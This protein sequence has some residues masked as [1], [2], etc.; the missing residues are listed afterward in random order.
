MVFRVGC[1]C[2]FLY[3]NRLLLLCDS[4]GCALDGSGDDALDKAQDHCLAV[5]VTGEGGSRRVRAEPFVQG[6]LPMLLSG[7]EW[8]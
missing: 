5:A 7:S 8:T 4:D 1:F 6:A 2:A 3:R